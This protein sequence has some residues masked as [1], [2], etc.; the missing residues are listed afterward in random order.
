MPTNHPIRDDDGEYFSED[1]SFGIESKSDA[2]A[3]R[4]WNPIV[5]MTTD[6]PANAALAQLVRDRLQPAT[7]QLTK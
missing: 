2:L 1:P 3:N 5:P 7:A 6:A 4:S